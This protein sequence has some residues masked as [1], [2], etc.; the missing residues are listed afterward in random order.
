M[1][2]VVKANPP[3]NNR[4]S[5]N[6]SIAPK[7]RK[8]K[9]RKM[10]KR[11]KRYFEHDTR[12]TIDDY[13]TNVR[14]IKLNN[15][16]S[17]YETKNVCVNSTATATTSSAVN[18]SANNVAIN[19]RK[20]AKKLN[21]INAKKSSIATTTQLQMQLIETQKQL[22]KQLRELQQQ[23]NRSQMSVVCVKCNEHTNCLSN[24]STNIENQHNSN[25]NDSNLI[26]KKCSL[27]THKTLPTDG[28]DAMTLR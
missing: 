19:K 15:Q 4:T 24:Q 11:K 17:I 16:I 28:N 1:Y 2:S 20:S 8:R 27:T 21:R 7:S 6:D 9:R 26:S 5:V 23:Q 3:S 22:Q 12:T 25:A 10:K 14:K 13:P 18:A